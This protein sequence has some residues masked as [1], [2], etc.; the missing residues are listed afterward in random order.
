MENASGSNVE[1]LYHL[2][3]DRVEALEFVVKD[4]PQV[5]SVVNVPLMELKLKSD[6]LICCINR[7]GKIITPG[8]RDTMQIGDTVIV[9]TTHQGLTD[10]S[11]ILKD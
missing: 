9:V 3:D 11:D 1:T 4:T 7:G 5:H 2:A 8:G 10:L 6:L